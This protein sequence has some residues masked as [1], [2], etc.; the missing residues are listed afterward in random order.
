MRSGRYVK[1]PNGQWVF[2][3]ERSGLTYLFDSEEAELGLPTP[4]S[5]RPTTRA[6]VQYSHP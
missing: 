3:A 1:N 5:A 6:R 4:T 2:V